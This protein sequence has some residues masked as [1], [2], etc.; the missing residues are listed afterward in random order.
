MKK[1]VI[2]LQSNLAA[3]TYYLYQVFCG[4]CDGHV[5]IWLDANCKNVG[6]LH[7]Q[8]SKKTPVK[9]VLEINADASFRAQKFALNYY[10]ED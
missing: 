2:T 7:L 10:T 3:K 5:E 9:E 8:K 4:Y 1:S 6:I